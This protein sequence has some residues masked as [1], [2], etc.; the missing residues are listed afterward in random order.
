MAAKSVTHE[1]LLKVE[2]KIREEQ[3][4]YRH[5]MKW[6]IQKCYVKI[7]EVSTE[8]VINS[9]ALMNIQDD[10]KEIKTMFQKH[11]EYEEGQLENLR[12]Y[13]D[14]KFASKWVEKLITSAVILILVWFAGFVGN[15]IISS[16]KDSRVSVASR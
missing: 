16:I 11:I 9:H 4:N 6:D 15:A 12:K 13:M 14:E 1:D 7:D 3:T 5:E 10:V 2:M 8:S